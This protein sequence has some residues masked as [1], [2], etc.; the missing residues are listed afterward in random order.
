MG[1]RFSIVIPT[2]NRAHFIAD[3]LRSVLRQGHPACEII[4]VNDGSTDN[5][6]SVIE[7]ITASQSNIV[8][9]NQKNSERG[10]AR[11]RG[12]KEATGDYVVYFDSDDL[13]L[14][15]YLSDLN[16]YIESCDSAPAIVAATYSIVIKE[17]PKNERLHR[18]KPGI[19]DRSALLKGNPFACHFAVSK[20]VELKPFLESRDFSTMEDWLYLLMNSKYH[21][22]H[23][24][25]SIGIQM[26][27]HDGQ[28]MKAD[29]QVIEARRNSLRW[30]IQNLD[31]NIQELKILKNHSNLFIAVHYANCEERL[32][33]LKHLGTAI[34]GGL[35]NRVWTYTFMRIL[36]GNS[37]SRKLTRRFIN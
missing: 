26:L 17:D 14:D 6:T 25:D 9:I 11:N 22:I 37:L 4:V 21:D 3:T 18:H 27:S 2:Y 35:C 34:T 23:V 19:Y 7:S 15:N 20:S 12:Y 36:L 30:I 13:M 24:I 29:L 10:A 1:T 28:S 31:L 5:T 32:L 16:R 8:L 33:A